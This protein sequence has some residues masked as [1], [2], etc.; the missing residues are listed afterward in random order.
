MLRNKLH[1]RDNPK[2]SR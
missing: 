2:I 1:Y